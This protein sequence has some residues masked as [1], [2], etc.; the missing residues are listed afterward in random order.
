MNDEI[1]IERVIVDTDDV[2]QSLQDLQYTLVQFLYQQKTVP[3]H[4]RD[5]A[6]GLFERLHR[7]D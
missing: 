4:I 1:K 6:V 2:K 5:I 7:N 3:P